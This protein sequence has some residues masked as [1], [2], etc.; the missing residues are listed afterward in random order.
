MIIGIANIIGCKN[1]NGVGQPPN[2]LIPPSLSGSPVVGQ[3]LT[4]S[5]GT[6]SGS[7]PI[8]FTYQWQRNGSDITGEVAS[9]YTLVQADAG[10]SISCLVYA[11]NIVTTASVSSDTLSIMDANAELFLTTTGITDNTIKTAINQLVIDLKNYGIW[12][13]SYAIYPFVGSTSATH[14]YNLI[15][16]LDTDAAYRII[17]SGGWTHS[18]TGI[19]ANGVNAYA[20][21]K[22]PMNLPSQNNVHLSI[23]CRTNTVITT[24]DIG[25][26]YSTISFNS[27]IQCRD[28]NLFSVRLNTN[29]LTNTTSSNTDASGFFQ[30]NRSNAT[31]VVTR[32]NNNTETTGANNST[33][34][35]AF[36]F[37]YY[38]GNCNFNNA[39]LGGYYSNREYAFAS[40]EQA[41]SST[42]TSNYYTAVQA[43]ET[44]LGRQV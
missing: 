24:V 21:T 14:K 4:C 9:T 28:S 44:T 13:K 36:T 25:C 41:L 6:W 22:I 5:D 42:E 11:T 20:D 29:G 40:L 39:P 31:Q 30:A 26:I 43:F 15:N 33:T 35:G 32:K 23:Y 19:K 34:A 2:N 12:S 10:K 16:P 1:T 3:V 38:I 18:S 17:F 7:L 27:Y 8:T 37:P